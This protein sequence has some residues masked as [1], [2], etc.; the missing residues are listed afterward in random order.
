[1][2]EMMKLAIHGGPKAKESENPPMFPGGMYYGTE[3]EEAVLKVLR[4]KRLFRYYGPYD[5]ISQAD[6]FEKEFARINGAKYALG[7]NSCTNA[8]MIALLAAGVNPGDEVIVPA[9]TFVASTAAIVAANAIP[10]IVEVD[11]SFTIDPT[12]VEKSITTKTKAIMPVHMRGNACN[13]DAIMAIAKKNNLVVIEDAAQANGGLYNGKRLGSIGD[14]GCFSFQYHKVIT[15]GEGGAIITDDL[16]LL[17]RAKAMHDTG[18]NWRDDATIEDN[19]AFP[20]FPGYNCR[21]TEI[22]GALMLVQLDRLDGIVSTMRN[23]ATQVRDTISAFEGKGVELRKMNSPDGDIGVCV[24][25][26]ADTV[27]MSEKISEALSA[28]GIDS[29]TMGSP[30]VPDWHIYSF[31]DH[32]INRRGNNDVGYPFTL[33]DR[34]YSSDMCPRTTDYL[35][36]V[37]HLDISPMLEQEDVDG[38]VS[39]INKV[40]SALL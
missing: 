30:G 10:V 29:S 21:M 27:E 2:S 14:A 26:M 24:M 6:L 22:A 7:M 20:A 31:W 35:R 25:F 1:M 38:I 17:N 5:S 36:R 32:I 23:Y 33:S 9:Y 8:L 15:A 40:L 18:A 13:M 16:V 28:E 12:E 3:E 34:T 19:N 37:V 4:S 39:G 11:K